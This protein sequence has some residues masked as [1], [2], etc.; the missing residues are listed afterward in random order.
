VTLNEQRQETVIDGQGKWKTVL[1]PMPAGGP[2]ELRIEDGKSV[3][4]LENVMVGEVWLCSGQSNMQWTVADSKDATDEIQAA[5]NYPMIRICS[6]PKLAGY[7]RTPQEKVFAEWKVCTSDSI[8]DFS[9]VAYQ[10]ARNLLQS[11]ALRGMAIG[12]IDSSFGGTRAEAWVDG[13]TL[14][15]NFNRSELRDSPFGVPISGCYHGMIHPLVPY[16]LRGVLWY[17]GES[18]AGRAYQY[19]HL[20]P[21]M[22][23]HWRTEWKQGDFPFYWVQLA[24]YLAVAAEP[25]DSAWAEL[26]EAQTMTLSADSAGALFNWKAVE[27]DRSL[28]VH[29]PKYIIGLLQ[30]SIE[31]MQGAPAANELARGMQD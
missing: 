25:K 18:N 23:Q 31:F 28:G 4:V 30:S 26:R 15:A 2:Y 24:D 7:S 3:W 19:R 10:F 17:Q 8:G 1:N 13:P 27:E 21:L 6:V 20:F 29:N 11:P 16:S 12:L 5:A 14:D 22:I 9:A